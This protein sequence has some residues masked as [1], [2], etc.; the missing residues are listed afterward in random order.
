MSYVFRYFM[1]YSKSL[2]SLD[3]IQLTMLHIE[4]TLSKNV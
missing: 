4:K 3:N 1:N 2:K